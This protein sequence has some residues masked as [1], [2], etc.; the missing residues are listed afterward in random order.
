MKR[1]AVRQA[2][3]LGAS[4]AERQDRDRPCAR[5]RSA[6]SGERR[7]PRR[8]PTSRR[9]RVRDAESTLSSVTAR[10]NLDERLMPR[11]QHRSLQCTALPH[12]RYISRAAIPRQPIVEIRKLRSVMNRSRPCARHHCRSARLGRRHHGAVRYAARRTLGSSWVRLRRAP[13]RRASRP[14]HNSP[15]AILRIAQDGLAFQSARS[16]PT[17]RSTRRG[18]S[19]RDT[20]AAHS[21]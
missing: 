21:C 16:S 6:G 1:S 13:A 4:R 3:R 17:C 2:Q 7:L 14:H 11:G 20:P 9:L 5:V 12:A 18:V 8:S 19:A 15:T 10:R